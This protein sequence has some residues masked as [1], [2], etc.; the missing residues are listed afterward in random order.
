VRRPSLDPVDVTSRVGMGFFGGPRPPPPA[1]TVCLIR[2]KPSLIAAPP[3]AFCGTVAVRA[4]YNLARD[5][6]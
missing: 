5:A 1:G 2:A 4:D 3:P 6:V